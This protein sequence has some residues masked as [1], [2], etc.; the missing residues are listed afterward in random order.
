MSQCPVCNS[1]VTVDGEQAIERFDDVLCRGCSD[2]FGPEQYAYREVFGEV[3]HT[4][5]NGLIFG[6]TGDVVV[7]HWCQECW[8]KRR[9]REKAA[10]YDVEDGDRLWDILEAADGELVADLIP[11]LVGG[12]AWVRV[13]DGDVQARH[14]VRKRTDDGKMAFDTEPRRDFDVAAFGDFFDDPDYR[15]RVLL[16]PAGETPFAEV[17]N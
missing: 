10:H 17:E 15:A 2:Q 5:E 3:A 14:T 11:M 6:P 4:V 8:N 7:R 1:T 12:R 13:V 9:G 16:K